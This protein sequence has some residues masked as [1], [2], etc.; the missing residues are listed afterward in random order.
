MAVSEA[1]Y[2]VFDI[3]GPALVAKREG[4][5]R[6][7]VSAFKGYDLVQICTAFK[8]LVANEFLLFAGRDDFEEKFTKGV[9]LYAPVPLNVVGNFWADDQVDAVRAKPAFEFDDPVFLSQETPSSFAEYCRFVGA[10][11]PRYWQ[12][13]YTRLGLDYTSASPAGNQPVEHTSRQ[14][15][16]SGLDPGRARR[17]LAA[18]SSRQGGSG[19]SKPVSGSRGFVLGCVA[20]PLFAWFLLVTVV[21]VCRRVVTP[22]TFWATSCGAACMFVVLW[23]LGALGFAWKIFF[24]TLAE[25]DERDLSD[26]NFMTSEECRAHEASPASR[27]DY[28]DDYGPRT[29]TRKQGG[30]IWITVLTL[31]LLGVLG[32]NNPAA[33]VVLDY[34][35]LGAIVLG[36]VLL[37]GMAVYREAYTI[38]G[39][40]DPPRVCDWHPA[41]RWP[42]KALEARKS[43][44]FRLRL[45]TVFLALAAT[46]V[47]SGASGTH[48]Y[49]YYS[50]LRWLAS[51]S[52]VGLVWRGAAQG[53]KWAWALVPVAILF[54]PIVPIHVSR[55]TWRTLDIAAA[56]VLA[57]AVTIIELATLLRKRQ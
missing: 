32:W 54:N 53:V 46:I 42:L 18:L 39:R 15:R 40:F 28:D 14:Y 8:L 29:W 57:L 25:P 41:L 43:V 27:R 30:L 23:G 1:C 13:I 24:D 2:V 12:K 26:P 48:S 45:A 33:S 55:E 51:L 47:L 22:D 6:K 19:R 4:H 10:D 11:D 31:F 16:T 38:D 5:V 49:S 34:V 21:A 3:V 37:V 17:C 44:N 56:V 50:T 20:A 35:F 9:E 36:P 7:P 52:A